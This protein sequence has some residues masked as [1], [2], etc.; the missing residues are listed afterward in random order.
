MSLIVKHSSQVV[1]SAGSTQHSKPLV[2]DQNFH[3][4]QQVQ[5]ICLNK[6]GMKWDGCRLGSQDS[7]V[8]EERLLQMYLPRPQR[9][10]P[11][12]FCNV[13][14][15]H[16]GGKPICGQR[17]MQWAAPGQRPNS[18]MEAAGLETFCWSNFCAWT[19]ALAWHMQ[20]VVT[21]CPKEGSAEVTSCDC[22]GGPSCGSG[23][24]WII[25]LSSCTSH[26]KSSRNA[27]LSGNSFC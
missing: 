27:L 8:E 7:K 12:H 20:D 19:A 10:E 3:F 24:A 17:E 15:R 14:C 13:L 26:V 21:P 16:Q 5:V 23:D 4:C 2:L 9:K 25:Q 11:Q 22:W 6:S 18:P 1:I